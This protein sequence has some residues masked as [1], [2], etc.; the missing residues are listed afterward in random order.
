[1]NGS[2]RL[3]AGI[4]TLIHQNKKQQQEAWPL[5]WEEGRLSKNISISTYVFF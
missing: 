4:E 3:K 2:L 1:M 5:V